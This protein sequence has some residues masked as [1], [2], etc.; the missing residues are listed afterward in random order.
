MMGSEYIPM[1]RTI[2]GIQVD[3][4]QKCPRC[5]RMAEIFELGVGIWICSACMDAILAELNIVDLR[6][7]E[8]EDGK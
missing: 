1:K 6:Y 3:P 8:K 7:K 5:G 2:S 4:P